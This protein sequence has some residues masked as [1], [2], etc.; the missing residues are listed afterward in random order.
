MSWLVFRLLKFLA[1]AVFAAGL[2]GGVLSARQRDRLFA[3]HWLATP[4]LLV[5]WLA[6]YGLMKA[7]GGSLAQPWIG[8]SILAS[9]VGLYGAVLAAQRPEARPLAGGLAAAG[10]VGG[11]ATMVLRDVGTSGQVGAAAFTLGAGVFAGALV[12]ARGGDHQ[13]DAAEARAATLRWFTWIARFE[14]AS[15]L[16]MLGVSIPLRK[17]AGIQ[18]DGGEGWVG[19]VHGVL[20]LVYLQALASAART[21]GWSAG[22]VALGFVASLVPFG[23]FWFERQ[24]AGAS[25]AK[26]ETAG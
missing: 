2:T 19:W 20:T 18:I 10:F 6:G 3:T 11:M 24:L 4:G 13:G 7:T 14:G 12:R 15:L 5:T 16:F 17:L 23:T 21:G 1:L 9:F 25:P 26:V 8:A 22:R